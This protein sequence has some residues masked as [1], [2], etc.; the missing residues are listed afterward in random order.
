MVSSYGLSH[1]LSPQN[2]SLL[3]LGIEPGFIIVSGSLNLQEH[4]KQFAPKYWLG[5]IP[6]L[7]EVQ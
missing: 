2:F 1:H 7:G 6:F 3:L 4:K 5:P